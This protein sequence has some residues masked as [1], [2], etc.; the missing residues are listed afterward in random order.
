MRPDGRE[1]E[2]EYFSESITVGRDER[3]QVRL[4]DSMVSRMHCIITL[5]GKRYIVKDLDSR[6]GTWVNGRKIA[7]RRHVKEA[8][9]I[10]VGPFRLMIRTD[11]TSSTVVREGARNTDDPLEE[12]PVPQQRQAEKVVQ[13]LGMISNYLSETSGDFKRTAS[14]RPR[15]ERLHRNLLCLY[16]ITEDLVV[17]TKD[18][19]EIL[20]YVMDEIFDIFSPSQATILLRD[21]ES[22]FPVPR[23]QRAH[24]GEEALRPISHT[25]VNRILTDRVAVITDDAQEDPRFM[26]GQSVIIDQ[27]RSV[28]AAPIWEGSNMLGVLYVDSVQIAGGFQREDMDLLTALGHQVA[29]AIQ[30][31]RLLD[32]IKEEAVRSAV[33]RQNLGRFHSPQVVDLIM[34]G[35]ADLEV[36][37]T[38]ATIFFCDIVGFT[39]LCSECTPAQL[40]QMLNLF[41]KIVNQGVFTEQGTLDKFIGDAAL[42]IFGAPLPQEDAPVRAVRTALLLRDEF[43]RALS[44]LPEALRFRV[45]YGIN[46]GQAIVGNFG[47]DE[48]MEYTILGHTV[49]LASRICDMAEPDRILVGPETWSRIEGMGLFKLTK[50]PPMR[51]KGLTQEVHLYEVDGFF[52]ANNGWG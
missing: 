1:E 16:R 21:N 45:R 32:R 52:S 14:T 15:R 28:M 34:K 12:D 9:V 24:A 33:I 44:S 5:D 7:G 18:V 40:Q 8:D 11:A 38:V 30:R 47:S 17:S 48:R 42:A 36:R 25:V 26:M 10:Q 27:I 19:D 43:A 31:R 13:P 50:L 49:N 2:Y 3:C 41:C 35:G 23:K 46:T 51:L 22:E 4:L 39:S 37:E 20:E 6:N 29:L